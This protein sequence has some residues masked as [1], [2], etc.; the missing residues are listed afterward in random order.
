[1]VLAPHGI[2]ERLRAVAEQRNPGRPVTDLVPTSWA[3]AR[4][5]IEQHIEAGL[6]KFVVRPGYSGDYRQFLDDFV[7]ELGPLQN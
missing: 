6:T 2:P 7:R 5:M 4:R 1:M 3:E